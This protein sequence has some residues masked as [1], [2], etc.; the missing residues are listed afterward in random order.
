MDVTKVRRVGIHQRGNG[1]TEEGGEGDVCEHRF[2]LACLV[3]AERVAGWG[4][5]EDKKNEETE[6]EEVEVSCPVCRAVGCVTREEWE[7][8]VAALE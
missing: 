7:E 1:K 6:D 3:S 2:H 8:G 5:S 4:G